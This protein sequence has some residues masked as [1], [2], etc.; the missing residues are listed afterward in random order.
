M[1]S[2][3]PCGTGLREAAISSDG[4]IEPAASPPLRQ[5]GRL[6]AWIALAGILA[7]LGYAGR[8]AGGEPPD[9]V[10]YL[11]STFVGALIQY[12]IMFVLILVIA[13]GFDRRLL[14]LRGAGAAPAPPW[15]GRSWHS[16]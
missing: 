13:H 9:D 11:W 7:A 5:T 14:A 15:A 3:G 16:S 12:A 8:F 2:D 6:V 10:L 4:L 1:W